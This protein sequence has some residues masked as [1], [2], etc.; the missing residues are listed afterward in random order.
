MPVLG[1]RLTVRVLEHWGQKR[2]MS[3]VGEAMGGGGGVRGWVQ[4]FF[5]CRVWLMTKHNLD[6]DGTY[7]WGP[8][9]SYVLRATWKT[10]SITTGFLM[11]AD[12]AWRKAWRVSVKSSI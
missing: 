4:S 11:L 6:I 8:V 3:K 9:A 10:Q 5:L 12:G 7:D 2:S 1:E